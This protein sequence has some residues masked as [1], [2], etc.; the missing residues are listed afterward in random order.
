MRGV[1][2]A[3]LLF[4]FACDP[5]TIDIAGEVVSVA[6]GDTMT[7]LTVSGER[8]KIRLEGIDAPERGQD[9]GTKAR[10]YLNDLCYGKVVT[11]ESRGE[12]QYGRT[13]GVVYLGDL[14]VNQE[15]VRNGLAWYYDYFVYDPKLD[16]LEQSARRQKLNIWSVKN[17]I[18]PYQYRKEKREKN[19]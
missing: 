4:F 12:D 5:G 8:I 16:S 9:Y 1:V 19:R 7:I 15:M 3:F 18:P 13:L 6:D 11:V 10:Q 14:N 17:P 2:L